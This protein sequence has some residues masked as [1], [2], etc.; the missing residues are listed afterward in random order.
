MGPRY[1][2]HKANSPRHL[3][4]ESSNE[5]PPDIWYLEHVWKGVNDRS[6]LH[7]A[8]VKYNVQTIFIPSV[9]PVRLVVSIDAQLGHV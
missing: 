8:I 3:S 7:N 1:I 4:E 6:Y 9:L 2:H 5:E